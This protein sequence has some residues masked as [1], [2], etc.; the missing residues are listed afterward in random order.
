MHYGMEFEND[1][2]WSGLKGWK[3]VSVKYW[4]ELCNNTNVIFDR[5]G[6]HFLNTEATAKRLKL[7]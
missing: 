6:Y 5:Y 7:I 4:V 2:F 1:I 3:P